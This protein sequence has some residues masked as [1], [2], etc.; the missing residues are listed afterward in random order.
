MSELPPVGVVGGGSF[1]RGLAL[2]AA[3]EGR[4]VVLWSRSPR[5]MGHEAVRPTSQMHELS[6]TE[7]LFL[8]VPSPHV[9]DLATQLGNH[10]DGR[11]LLVHVSRGLVGPEIRTLSQVLRTETPC[12]RVGSLAGPLLANALA[13]GE[14][15][16]AVVGTQFPEVA[17]A[18]REAI[19]G[20]RMR[21]YE[22]NDVLGVE[23]ASA[24]VGLLVLVIGYLQGIGMSPASLSVLAT[25]GMAEAARI[26]GTLGAS[27]RTFS[28][29]AGFG[30]LLAAIAGDDRPEIRLGRALAKGTAFQDAAQ[31][32]GAHIEGLGIARRAAD[33]STRLGLEAPITETV[34]AV[35]EGRMDTEQ[36][37]QELMAREARAE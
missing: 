33:Y 8:A 15:G 9:P 11:H 10:L 7:L 36:A 12:R 24:M 37:I 31:H 18:V 35:M 28:G 23:V 14:P 32:A 2:A 30:D 27:E 25:R 20:S 6:R 21:I 29:L 34:A 16:G 3:R 26:G 19:G 22:T 5:D 13:E 1:G 4:E 17:Q